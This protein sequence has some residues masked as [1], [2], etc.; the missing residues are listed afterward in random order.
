MKHLD[1]ISIPK[2]K[3][4]T[5]ESE[6][7]YSFPF[8][9]RISFL[10]LI[11]KIK[12]TIHQ[13]GIN[14]DF[15]KG[16]INTVESI[17]ELMQPI[18]D[19][20]VI[21]KHRFLID[22]LLSSVFS[23]AGNNT[24]IK[25]TGSPFG[26][27]IL[28]AT[29]IFKEI[30]SME[31]GIPQITNY[32]PVQLNE[33]KL[34]IAYST[35]LKQI[36]GVEASLMQTFLFTIPDRKT[37]LNRHYHIE[38]NPDFAR[39]IPTKP[40][41]P[42]SP[43]ELSELQKKLLNPDEIRHDIDPNYF[44][45]QGLSM[46]QAVDITEPT[47]LSLLKDE[48]LKKE[49]LQ[50]VRHF[51]KLE[52]SLKDMFRLP[53]LKLG[54]VA[55]NPNQNTYENASPA[56]WNSFI[57]QDSREVCSMDLNGCIYDQSVRQNQPIV[58]EDLTALDHIG[59]IEQCILQKNIKNILVS[60]LMDNG[61]IIGMLEL[62]SPNP[63][64]LNS[65]SIPKLE[66][67]IPLFT[68]AVK[69]KLEDISTEVE[70]IKQKEFT[71]IHPTVAWKFNQAAFNLKK[72]REMGI[73]AE[74]EPIIFEDVYPLFGQSDIRG[75][76]QERNNSIQKDLTE[77]LDLS[78]NVIQVIQNKTQLP[79]LDEILFRIKKHELHIQEGVNAGDE[80][81]ILDFIKNE[82]ET[83]FE[84]FKDVDPEI[85]QSIQHYQQ[86]LDPTL[87]IIYKQRKAFEQ[88]LTK[89]NEKVST[90]L[91]FEEARAQKMFP[92]YFEKY[93][94]DGVEYNIYIGESMLKDR[95]FNPIYLENMRLWQLEIMCNIALK[96]EKLKPFL[97]IPLSTTQLIL[98]HSSPL[99][100]RFRQDEKQFDVD[101]AYNIRYE[102]VKKRIDKAYIKGTKERLT[103]PGKI[104]I[105]YTRDKE[106]E[107]YKK[108]I[109]FLQYK[110]L[111]ESEIE[112][113]E[114]EELQGASGLKAIRV[115]VH[116]PA[117]ES[118]V[119]IQNYT[120]PENDTKHFEPLVG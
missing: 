51:R 42:F 105:V 3:L 22:A 16:L 2:N 30:L 112:Y 120:L 52:S 14:G 118:T 109:E 66:D 24:E 53:D 110:G 65:Y 43:Q 40:I 78:K 59:E 10:P 61:E 113:L 68:N 26:F 97:P 83:L 99:S 114:L 37:K 17:P 82:I 96:T 41:K 36:Y 116:L 58:I 75:S 38:I 60:P 11:E 88:S 92:H 86:S 56:I 104:A 72:K 107:E 32:D 48:L 57:T 84:Y 34:S 102:I 46:I 39:V 74:I 119:A 19:E 4:N 64:D 73:E 76:S 93:K 90:Y 70:V 50:S 98:V 106:I 117:E 13:S 94:T 95:K 23:F 44:E 115:R 101:G 9:S 5:Q 8:K 20:S 33:K 54:L 63:G 31:N 67:I 79:L 12:N 100:I 69:R 18:D 91:D 62:G 27:D 77:Q 1:T 15:W 25:A 29:P 55:F 80:V 71:A 103:Q 87:K 21:K 108:H 89:I 49:A 35:I 111:L 7:Q 28:Y 6:I 85:H 47:V 45:F 81:S